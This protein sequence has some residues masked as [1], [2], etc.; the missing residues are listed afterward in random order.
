M[1]WTIC[2]SAAPMQILC[3][4]LR[5]PNALFALYARGG[6][7]GSRFRPNPR[8]PRWGGPARERREARVG[9]GIFGSLPRW[10]RGRCVSEPELSFSPFLGCDESWLTPEASATLPCTVPLSGGP[11]RGSS[12]TSVPLQP[13][14]LLLLRRSQPPLCPVWLG[15]SYIVNAACHLGPLALILIYHDTCSCSHTIFSRS[16][17]HHTTTHTSILARHEVH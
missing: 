16:H 3:S 13:V 8:T 10:R 17:S 14:S 2:S 12:V 5:L 4:S 1:G 9:R 11:G 6:Q 7:P 15:A